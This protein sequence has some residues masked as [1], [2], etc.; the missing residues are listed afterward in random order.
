MTDPKLPLPNSLRSLQESRPFRCS[1][2]RPPGLC[3]LRPGDPPA[4]EGKR[5]RGGRTEGVSKRRFSFSSYS[6]TSSSSAAQPAAVEEEAA[7][8]AEAARRLLGFLEGMGMGGLHGE[9]M[10]TD[11][12][13][14]E[15][16]LQS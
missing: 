5:K 1:P 13:G 11:R 6:K 12:L 10:R 9:L 8:A 3:T 4:K 2:L 16:L 7:E 15:L 14:R